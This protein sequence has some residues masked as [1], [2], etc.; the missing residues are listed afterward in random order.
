MRFVKAALESLREQD[1]RG[2]GRREA[3]SINDGG[4]DR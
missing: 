1:L 4:N 2:N 3:P